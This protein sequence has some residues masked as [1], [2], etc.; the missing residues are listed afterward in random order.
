MQQERP[1]THDNYTAGAQPSPATNEQGAGIQCEL[2]AASLRATAAGLTRWDTAFDLL[3]DPTRIRVLVALHAAPGASVTDLANAVGIAP[4]ATTKA[5]QTMAGAGL[6]AGT[7][8]GR[9]KRWRIVDSEVHQL[10][11]RVGSPHTALHP[12]DDH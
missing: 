9:F 11:H 12:E 8:D 3:S 4:N 7:R 1:G 10:I 5:L 2:A 6:V